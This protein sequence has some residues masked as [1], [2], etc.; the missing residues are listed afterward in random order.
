MRPVFQ[1]LGDA[2]VYSCTFDTTYAYEQFVPEHLLAYQLSGQTHIYHQRG[3]LV[4]EEG[5]LLLARGNQF[6]KSKKVPGANNEYKC[7]SVV[8]TTERLRQFASENDIVCA[9][10]YSGGKNIIL[11]PDSFFK[12]YFD[13]ITP[14]IKEWKNVST[15]MAT[16]K[17]HEAIA[18]LVHLRP[19]L[20]SFLFDFADPHKQDLEAFMLKNFQYNA[21]LEN[22]ARLSGRSLT[23][24]K[25]EFAQTFKTSP[26]KWLKDK[27][28][29]EAYYLIRQKNR[30]P[31]D[32]YL[33][34]GFENLSHFYS[35]FK[36]KY[37]MTP[38]EI[39]PQNHDH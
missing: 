12:S 34:L 29:S 7:L 31:Q 22:F 39:K 10:K 27:R 18:L 5:Q 13:S 21:P 19:G 20:Q 26:A 9:E 4:L 36:H 24:F 1:R 28:L 6:A 23:G 14:Y 16:L 25:R 33:D 30:K 38:A 11:E 3:E 15:R 2:F 8:M 17:V 35:S 37:G 32:F